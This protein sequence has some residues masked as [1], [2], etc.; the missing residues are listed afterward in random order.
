MGGWVGWLV[1]F[2][3]MYAILS[4]FLWCELGAIKLTKA[5]LVQTILTSGVRQT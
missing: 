2:C 4:S 3:L 1:D 5:H